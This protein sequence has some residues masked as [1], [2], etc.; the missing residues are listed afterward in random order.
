MSNSEFVCECGRDGYK[1]DEKG[2]V[3]CKKCLKEALAIPQLVSLKVQGRNE[4]C[5][6]GSGKKFKRCCI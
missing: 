2:E 4:L 5:S 1:T 6:C 3:W